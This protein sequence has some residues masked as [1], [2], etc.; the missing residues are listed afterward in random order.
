MWAAFGAATPG[1]GGERTVGLGLP[2]A[3]IT[4][5]DT[6]ADMPP[7]PKLTVRRQRGSRIVA[8]ACTILIGATGC[9]LLPGGAGSPGDSGAHSTET[10]TT[11]AG[12]PPVLVPGGT[13]AENLPSFTEVLRRYG[14]ES[15][16]IEGRPIVDAIVA[17]GFDRAT[18]QVSFDRT[19]TNLVADF[20]F[21]SVRIADSC[22]LG[23]ISTADRSV[24]A[25]VETAVGPDGSI[26]IIGKTRPLD[27]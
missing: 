24:A 14:A 9:S 27:W 21:V 10:P 8:L 12:P 26:C 16:P 25:V 5:G 20:I 6:L 15:A 13:A 17:A 7:S 11:P 2:A 22:L 23:Q 4:P 18:M 1:D 19:Q 3:A